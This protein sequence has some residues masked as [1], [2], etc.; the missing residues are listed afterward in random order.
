MKESTSSHAVV[1]IFTVFWM[2]PSPKIN[3]VRLKINGV[4]LELIDVAGAALLLLL[5]IFDH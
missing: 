3:G 4:R 5:N 1:I 2:L